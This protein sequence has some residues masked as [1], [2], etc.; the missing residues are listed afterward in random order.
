ML[1]RLIVCLLQGS[2]VDAGSESFKKPRRSERLSQRIE[3]DVIKTPISHKQHLPSPVT[4]IVSESTDEFSKE[5][6]AT[7][8][9]RS[10]QLAHSQAALA[11]SSPP[12]DTQAFSQTTVDPNAPLSDEVEDEVKEG[13]WGYLLPMDTRYG[14]TCV[15]L[16]KRGSCPNPDTVADSVNSGKKKATRKG[17]RA[18]LKEQ[19]T[20][21]KKQRDGG[22]AS[23]GYLIGRHP[24]CDIQVEDPIVSNRH[25]L[26]FAEHKGTDSV[27]IL[28]DLS[29]NGTFVNDQIV[30]RNQRRE[31][32]EYDEIAVMDKARFIFRYPK[33]R[34]ANAF[35]QQYTPVEKLGKGHFAEVYLCI[36]KATGQRYAVKV[37]TKTPGVE[38]RSKNE[39]LQQEIAMLMGVSHP[40]VLCLKDTFNESNAVYL[41]LELAPEGELF[42]FIVK[43]QKLTEAEC[44]KLFTQL[45][46]GIKYLHDR[47]IVHRDIKPENIL[48]VDKDLHVKLADF[49]LAKIIGEE[50]FTT[51]LCGTPSYVAPEILADNRHRKYTKAVDIWSLGVVLYIC[52]CGFPPF[53]DE[54]TSADFPYTLSEQIRKGKFDYPSP[55]WDPVGD[56]ALDLIDAMLVVDPEKRYTVDQCLTHPWMTQKMP[57]V[58]DSTNGLVSGIQGLEMSRRGVVRERTLLSSINTV[59]VVNRIPGKDDKPDVKV[60]VKNPGMTPK[61][62]ARPDDERDPEEFSQMG[63]KGDQPL[64]GDDG[65]SRY[66]A[67]DIAK[68]K[69]KGKAKANGN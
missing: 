61:K 40:N 13:V 69:G 59:H 27:A 25:C 50:S 10:S 45:F 39:G 7:P 47:N 9:A 4:H 6:T 17:P 53:S 24:E 46:Q 64:Y 67:A 28:E 57:G 1:R 22:L 14:G 8:D 19:E 65:N 20:Y 41:V 35:L 2:P 26:F 66:S 63:G 33:N 23:G 29:S 52:L 15:V 16:R 5:T 18:L 11:F 36:E 42:N 49:G 56:L 31:L 38:E 44:R 62:E 21:D 58:N 34:Q 30:G 48:L 55:Y 68:P 60:H 37:F 12:Q 51:T 43:K 3:N 54:L 32:K